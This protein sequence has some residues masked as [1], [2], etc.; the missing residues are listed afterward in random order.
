MR[1]ESPFY[2]RRNHRRAAGQIEGTVEYVNKAPNGRHDKEANDAVIDH[3]LAVLPLLLVREPE[4]TDDHVNNGER[5]DDVDEVVEKD[6]DAVNHSDEAT[7]PQIG[8]R[9]SSEAT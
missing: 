6:D 3:L 5:G 2:G 9:A 4:G 1:L 7:R 8:A